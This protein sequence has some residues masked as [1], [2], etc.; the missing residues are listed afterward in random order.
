[1]VLIVINR[2]DS[3]FTESVIRSNVLIGF[4][5]YSTNNQPPISLKNENF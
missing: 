5:N 1:M 4:N 2:R 3:R